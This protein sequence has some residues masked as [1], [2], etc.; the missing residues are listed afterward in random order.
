VEWGQF[1]FDFGYF[2]DVGFQ[3]RT[4]EKILAIVTPWGASLSFG[5]EF[6][7]R[8]GNETGMLHLRLFY[9]LFRFCS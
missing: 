8:L 4:Q 5:S 2:I 3:A 9:V 1:F 7:L 6:A